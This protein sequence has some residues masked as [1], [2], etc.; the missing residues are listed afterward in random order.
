VRPRKGGGE[1]LL[2]AAL[3]FQLQ[4]AVRSGELLLLLPQRMLLLLLLLL[5]RLLLAVLE[6]PAAG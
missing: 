3:G 4:A 6:V 5:L 1:L 2:A